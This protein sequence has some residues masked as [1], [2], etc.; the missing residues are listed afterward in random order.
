MIRDDGRPVGQAR[1][2]S[3]PLVEAGTDGRCGL[4]ER[5]RLYPPAATPAG[6]LPHHAR[7]RHPRSTLLRVLRS[8]IA[9][10][11]AGRRAEASALVRAL[12]AASDEELA[13]QAVLRELAM[14]RVE[15]HCSYEAR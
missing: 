2:E 6:P 8:V 5:G 9:L 11:E 1:S 4:A 3:I 7:R 14:S 10:A 13:R 15:R 12:R